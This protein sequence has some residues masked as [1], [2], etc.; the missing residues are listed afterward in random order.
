MMRTVPGNKKNIA[1]AKTIVKRECF[2]QPKLTV[3]QPGD[4]YEQEAD[5][6]AEQVMRT[7]GENKQMFFQPQI[8]ALNTIQKK[9]AH[10]EEEDNKVQMKS[11][12]AVAAAEAPAIVHDTIKNTGNPLDAATK[13]F[14]ESRFGY[15]F[16][17]VHIHNDTLAHQSSSAINAKAYTSGNHIVFGAEEY[18]PATNAGK[19]LLAHELTHVIQQKSAQNKLNI[20]RQSLTIDDFIQWAPALPSLGLGAMIATPGAIITIGGIALAADTWIKLEQIKTMIE[21]RTGQKVT[22]ASL[23]SAIYNQKICPPFSSIAGLIP[24]INVSG[25]SSKFGDLAEMIIIKD[26]CKT[27]TCKTETHYFDD[28]TPKNYVQHLYFNNPNI[29]K[30]GFNSLDKHK[31]HLQRPDILDSTENS[32]VYYEIKPNSVYGIRDGISKLSNLNTYMS[33]FR[34]PYVPGTTYLNNAKEISLANGA[35]TFR[36]FR[37]KQ[38][39][40]L[41]VYDICFRLI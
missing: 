9:C 21:S 12:E 2:F 5:T 13:S 39:P 26:Y 14:M 41:I 34:P 23:A 8:T 30:N 17:D 22:V 40:G 35:L 24:G 19:Q 33:S 32:R 7:P 37:L 36:F 10:C 29:G 20:Q 27:Y 3:N 25:E 38:V 4:K 28:R 16:S 1:A 11:N 6:V 18:Q 15:D 31:S